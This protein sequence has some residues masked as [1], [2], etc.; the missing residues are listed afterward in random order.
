[1]YQPFFRDVST[2][3]GV[4]GYVGSECAQPGGAFSNLIG[5]EP[6]G[7][8]GTPVFLRALRILLFDVV[9]L[10]LFMRCMYPCFICRKTGST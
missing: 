7:M 4:C 3:Y 2:N 8:A 9:L 5:G 1:M 6:L 10:F